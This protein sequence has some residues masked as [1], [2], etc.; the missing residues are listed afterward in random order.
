MKRWIRLHGLG[1]FL[2][3]VIIFAAIWLLVIDDVVE[4]VIEKAGTAKL[5]AKVEL[6]SADLS[7]FPAGLALSRLQVTNPDEP[8]KNAVEIAKIQVSLDILNLFRRKIIIDDMILD[9]IRFDTSRPTSGAVISRPKAGSRGAAPSE[10]EVPSSS[11]T[12]P[13]K[14][15]CTEFE[16]PSLQKANV[17]DI[18]NSEELYSIKEMSSLRAD[19]DAEKGKW[20]KQITSLPGK[21]KF[22]GYKKRIEDLKSMKGGLTGILTASK[23]ITAV[24]KDI[25]KDIKE[26]KT[27][28]K[29]FDTKLSTYKKRFKGLQ[30]APQQDIQRLKAKY[31]P[32][33]SNISN[34]GPLLFS[35][36]LCKWS[37]KA[38]RWYEKIKPHL[39]KTKTKE[40]GK[41]V[42]KPVRGKGV[43]I[44]Y[45]EHA[46]LPDFLI[47]RTKASIILPIGNLAGKIHNI[48]P[49]QDVLGIPMTFEFSGEKMKT[50]ES[51]KIDGVFD[52]TMPDS[53]NS[54]IN[55]NLNAL[56]VMDVSLTDSKAFPV[57]LN[58]A[59][60]NV[61]LTAFLEGNQID[62]RIE[63][64]L[65]GVKLSSSTSDDAGLL[66]Q[67][68]GAVLSDVKQVT[69][70]ADVKGPIDNYQINIKSNVDDVLKSAIG[71]TVKK[72][73]A[74][75]EKELT[76]AV[77]SK[78]KGPLG[79]TSKSLGGFGGL[80][81]ELTR[82]LNS[83]NGLL[84]GIKFP[85]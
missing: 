70:T 28:I 48:T 8:M 47:K 32:S 36:G 58:K 73:A 50:L 38:F 83:G 43:N 42:V 5:G 40:N 11:G 52:A 64:A 59:S 34:L 16:L 35:K 74:K 1:I 10:T 18:L 33:I 53:T 25:Q 76:Q 24:Q 79:Q 72:A 61:D 71:K 66:I 46:P 6:D 17:K 39:K 65:N 37:E 31:I 29:T 54:N 82:R 55:M 20:Q 60:T 30:L 75:L 26:I 3:V 14:Q 2:I 49:D 4:G 21:A 78:V 45:K 80:R 15:K 22:A 62:A 12:D 7:L 27:S 41:E 19:I 13:E 23:D 9:G 68:M 77:L 85:L 56:Q 84:K 44:R 67:S 69:G 63:A 81:N 51:I 57:T